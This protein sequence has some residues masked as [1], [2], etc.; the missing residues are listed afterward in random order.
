[1]T[2]SA[3]IMS[4]FRSAT[5]AAGRHDPDRAQISVA[6]RRN[7]AR[8]NK[9]AGHRARPS[10]IGLSGAAYFFGASAGLAAPSAGLVPS[11]GAAAAP[12]SAAVGSG[13][14]LSESERR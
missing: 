14:G 9:T 5:S 1:M 4:V 7:A 12:A 6:N 3:P 2:D 11:A 13:F 8:E 10:N